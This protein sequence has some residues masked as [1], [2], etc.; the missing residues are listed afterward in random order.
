M[1]E[2]DKLI[3]SD[4]ELERLGDEFLSIVKETGRQPMPFYMF[5]AANLRGS[6]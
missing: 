3:L 6:L 4:D 5:V 2:F 1:V